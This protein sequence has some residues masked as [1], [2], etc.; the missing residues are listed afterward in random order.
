MR[1]IKLLRP[2]AL[3]IVLL[4]TMIGILLAYTGVVSDWELNFPEECVEW[5][6]NTCVRLA[7]HTG[8]PDYY[9][10][11]YTAM[12]TPDGY[13]LSGTKVK[14]E[15]WCSSI[16]VVPQGCNSQ[17]IP[18]DLGCGDTAEPWVLTYTGCSGIQG[19]NWIRYSVEGG[20]GAYLR[21]YPLEYTSTYT[22]AYGG[23]PT[24]ATVDGADFDGA[25]SWEL[26]A[27]ASISNSLLS[28]AAGAYAEQD[29]I[30]QAQVYTATIIARNTGTEDL[31]L[32]L[33]RDGNIVATDQISVT[34]D[35]Q[36]HEV[37]ANLETDVTGDGI[38]W[39]SSD[40]SYQVDY[41]CLHPT[42]GTSTCSS[43]TRTFD[44]EDGY[45]AE[46]GYGYSQHWRGIEYPFGGY[47]GGAP[48]WNQ[49]MGLDGHF[50]SAAALAAKVA[51]TIRYDYMVVPQVITVTSTVNPPFGGTTIQILTSQDGQDW[52]IANEVEFNS[53][54]TDV[55]TVAVNYLSPVY[56]AVAQLTDSGIPIPV[57]MAI[58]NQIE[59][60]ACYQ[61]P[62]TFS[63]CIV[64]DPD[65]DEADGYPSAFYWDGYYSPVP[66]AA[67]LQETGFVAQHI[68]PPWAGSYDLEIV[69]S[70]TETPCTWNIQFT[71]Y[72]SAVKVAELARQCLPRSEQVYTTTF[73]LPASALTLWI[74][75][76]VGDSSI[77]RICLH[78][79]GG[80]GQC[81][82]A[83]PDLHG[84][85]G[86][87][88]DYYD[89]GGQL[90]IPHDGTLAA[91]GVHYQA[92]DPPYLLEL[93]VSPAVTATQ[94]DL[95]INHGSIPGTDDSDE[96]H[97]VSETSYITYG[98]YAEI[99]GG[100]GP[101]L[102]NAG[103]GDVAVLRYCLKPATGV[104]TNPYP[105]PFVCVSVKNADFTEGLTDW[106]SQNVIAFNGIASFG[107]DAYVSQGLGDLGGPYSSTV[108]WL[109]DAYDST[110]ATLTVASDAGSV[111]SSH[112]FTPGNPRFWDDSASIEGETTITVSAQSAGLNLDFICLYTGESGD[113]PPPLPSDPDEPGSV[114]IPPGG[115][116]AE[117]IAPPMG[118]LPSITETL[119]SLWPWGGTMTNY[120]VL[121][122]YNTAWVRFIGCTLDSYVTWFKD[123]FWGE[124]WRFGFG[125]N[126]LRAKLDQII[127][128][129]ALLNVLEA[130]Q[131]IAAALEVIKTAVTT[132][133]DVLSAIGT[134]IGIIVAIV[135]IVFAIIWMVLSFVLTLFAKLYYAMGGSSCSAINIGTENYAILAG[136]Q[137]AQDAIA[138]TPLVYLT[139]IAANLLVFRF[140]MWV[141][142][143]FK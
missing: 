67:V 36:F 127:F 104:I 80:S 70:S 107:N 22:P 55:I 90:V 7:V 93:I 45:V 51:A 14:W 75:Q 17:V 20:G 19:E 142:G 106:D 42:Y 84:S 136:W 41:I 94:A 125:G 88:G 99:S 77:S 30:I 62:N 126:G 34:A 33:I 91:L 71:N 138:T 115:E 87:V 39:L 141:M 32:A 15:N 110:V 54:Q 6:G 72:G 113:V 100:F 92:S 134:A 76:A 49:F 10:I 31:L 46:A 73:D 58:I 128:L 140:F 130:I 60:D 50:Q 52:S 9:Y 57:N 25:G 131:A 48:V 65:L 21:L 122:A 83:N 119:V 43:E 118:I 26:S 82:N 117:C 68:T 132:I 124:P 108:R 13:V 120:E 135:G 116:A 40:G 29:F 137:F 4:A 133:A 56:L 112:S 81:L 53:G 16:Q 79:A 47:A 114:E 8:K 37:E 96:T 28:L 38:L 89:S 95:T 2:F 129:L 11:T 5:D 12:V 44:F 139:L 69:A 24:C 3:A 59:M 23:W 1:L 111:D 78:P 101:T 86:Y 123:V 121:M 18:W 102:W 35:G 109:G 97:T 74:E 61:G 66:G 98:L 105:N 103:E 63:E 27:G 64:G 143:R 85:A